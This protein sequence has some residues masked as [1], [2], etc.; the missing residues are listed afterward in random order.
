LIEEQS[1]IDFLFPIL[2]KF[3][4][5]LEEKDIKNK[6]VQIFNKQVKDL[7]VKQLD[8]FYLNLVRED[9]NIKLLDSIDNLIKAKYNGK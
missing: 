1:N 8:I 5:D 3:T 4:F 7:S 9:K 6:S 2:N